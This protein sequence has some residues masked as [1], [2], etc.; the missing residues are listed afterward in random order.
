MFIFDDMN[1]ELKNKDVAGLVKMHRHIKSKVIL[2]SQ[3]VND[4]KPESRRQ[5]DYWILF[6][7]H[8][9]E[10]LEELFPMLDSQYDFETFYAVYQYATSK[11]YNFLFIDANKDTFKKN[12]TTELEIINS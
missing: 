2:S 9:R 8:S 6:G 7:G 12:F 3:W 11:P 1:H 5:M 4:L 10:K